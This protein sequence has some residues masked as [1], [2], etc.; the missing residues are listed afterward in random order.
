VREVLV[1]GPERNVRKEIEDGILLPPLPSEAKVRDEGW[2]KSMNSVQPIM[3]PLPEVRLF[4]TALYRLKLE[5]NGEETA[6]MPYVD[7]SQFRTSSSKAERM[8]EGAVPGTKNSARKSTVLATAK[9]QNKASKEEKVAENRKKLELS[10]STAAED[11]LRKSV[12][13][14]PKAVPPVWS[15]ALLADELSDPFSKLP[16]HEEYDRSSRYTHSILYGFNTEF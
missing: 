16:S 15:H 9:T 7:S 10:Q 13:E 5:N 2:G 6:P 14:G 8:A 12:V 1:W 3:K 4:R 11:S